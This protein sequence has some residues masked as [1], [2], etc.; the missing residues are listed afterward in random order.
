M[1]YNYF[2]VYHWEN[3]YSSGDGNTSVRVK[4]KILKIED[5]RDVERV[6]S[7]SMKFDKVM[8]LSFQLFK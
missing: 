1:K 8:I 3:G 7:V 2:I 4:D 5:V 6:M